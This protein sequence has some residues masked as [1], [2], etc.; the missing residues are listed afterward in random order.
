M[1]KYI[2]AILP[3]GKGVRTILE[4]E[5]EEIE[6]KRVKNDRLPKD[7]MTPKYDC[8]IKKVIYIEKG[9]LKN[10]NYA[11]IDNFIK[12]HNNLITSSFLDLDI[13]LKIYPNVFE[14]MKKEMSE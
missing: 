1:I 11:D 3:I 2:E 9:W 7:W 4:V 12:K 5:A 8:K 13:L 14:K 6:D 10:H